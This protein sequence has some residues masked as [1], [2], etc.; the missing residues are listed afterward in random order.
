MDKN[1]KGYVNL[2]MTVTNEKKENLLPLNKKDIEEIDALIES[3][4][5]GGIGAKYA[6]K[7]ALNLRFGLNGGQFTIRQTA[8]LLGVSPAGVRQKTI[9]AIKKL[10]R[11]QKIRQLKKFF[12]Y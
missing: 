9:V 3:L 8:K 6:F 1:Y 4:G 10:Q 11:P 5:K 2:L 7:E 12:S